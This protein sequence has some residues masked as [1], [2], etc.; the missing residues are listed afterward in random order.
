MLAANRAAPI[1]RKRSQRLAKTPPLPPKSAAENL[2]EIYCG[3]AGNGRAC[4]RLR[5]LRA[6]TALAF[7]FSRIPRSPFAHQLRSASIRRH[8][9][10]ESIF[11][12]YELE[13][14]FIDA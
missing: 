8:A 7:R 11:A 13:H 6:Q 9:S 5:P 1:A 2:L 10:D 14:R 3:S 4:P 12:N